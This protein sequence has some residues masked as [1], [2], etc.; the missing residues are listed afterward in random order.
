MQ[1][2]RL[3]KL[4]VA[5]LEERKADDIRVLDVRNLTDVTDYMI[6]ASGR[7]SRQVNAIAE[8]VVECCKAAKMRPNGVEGD[9]VGEWV[10]V[11]VFDV[12]VHVMVPE[13]RDFYQLEKLWD[14]RAIDKPAARNAA[15]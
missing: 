1:S 5:A 3:C 7:S 8:H 2:K 6:V 9:D 11:D 14:G 13:T 10:L 4:V 15:G 12:I